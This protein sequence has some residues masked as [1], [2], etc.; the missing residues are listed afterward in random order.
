ML[1]IPLRDGGDVLSAKHADFK[2]LICAR[3][4]L[5]AGGFE[6]GEGL[7]D[8]VVGVDVGGDGLAGAFVRDQLAGGGEVD[9]VDVWVSVEVSM[10][11][12]AGRKGGWDGGHT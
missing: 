8:D 5:G 7:V 4:E 3:R 2:A 9:A 10:V 6:V 12:C 1:Q 11:L